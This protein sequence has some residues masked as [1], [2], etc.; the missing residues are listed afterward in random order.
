MNVPAF[1]RKTVSFT[2]VDSKV[3]TKAG[4]RIEDA[5]WN[6]A[7]RPATSAFLSRTVSSALQA[8]PKVG[9][10]PWWH[11]KPC[12]KD[13][14]QEEAK[15]K[16][17]QD[18]LALVKKRNERQQLGAAATTPRTAQATTPRIALASL[19]AT[20]MPPARAGL[21]RR[22]FQGSISKQAIEESRLAGA[23]FD[24]MNQCHNGLLSLDE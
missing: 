19:T 11:K 22:N 17:R 1:V 14:R 6:Q 18:A 7:S 8:A 4:P 21:L 12:E 3:D 13:R 15:A 9:D 20:T 10:A 24:R 16:P 23:E 5:P 2:K